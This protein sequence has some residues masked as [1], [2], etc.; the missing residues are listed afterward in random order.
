MDQIRKRFF[1][2]ATLLWSLIIWAWSCA[3]EMWWSERGLA[4]LTLVRGA[5]CDVISGEFL[6]HLNLYLNWP[7]DST[8][9]Q[10]NRYHRK[11]FFILKWRLK[12]CRP[13]ICFF[14]S[15]FYPASLRLKT[16]LW[17]NPEINKQIIHYKN[18]Y[19][20]R[21]VSY[22]YIF[23]SKLHVTFHY[24]VSGFLLKCMSNF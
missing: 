21:M 7:T 3:G 8:N 18:K 20:S 22:L 11:A 23:Y 24:C 16:S 4:A 12:R 5:H 17:Q 13:N 10:H 6:K 19:A 15:F 14:W 9:S 2:P 1:S